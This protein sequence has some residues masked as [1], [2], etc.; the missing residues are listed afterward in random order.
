MSHY[1]TR[2]SDGTNNGLLLL[3]PHAIDLIGPRRFSLISFWIF[4]SRTSRE[5]WKVGDRFYCDDG[6]LSGWVFLPCF[7][8]HNDRAFLNF[9]EALES[10]DFFTLVEDQI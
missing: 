8:N 7:V 9:A 6:D 5:C 1:R 4:G 10:N 2:I 3:P